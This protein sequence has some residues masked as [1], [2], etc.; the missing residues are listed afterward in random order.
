MK[1][2]VLRFSAVVRREMVRCCMIILGVASFSLIDAFYT[3][4][5]ANIIDRVTRQTVILRGFGLGCWLL[6]EGYMFGGGGNID[7]PRYLEQ[8]VTNLIGATDAHQFWMLWY[9]NYLVEQDI[10]DMRRW[11]CN[12]IRP[13]L[14]NNVIQ[15]RDGQ[16]ANPPYIYNDWGWEILDSLVT[17]CDRWHVGIIWDMHAAPGGQNNQ[18]ISDADGTARL[19]ADTTTYWPRTRDIW[20]QIAARY[21]NRRSII[22]YDLLNEPL[23]SNIGYNSALL[24]KLYVQL[25]TVIRTVDTAGIIFVEGQ[26]WARDFAILAPLTWDKHLAVAFHEYP[27]VTSFANMT[28]NANGTPYDWGALRT[29]YTIPLWHGETGEQGPPYTRNAQSTDFCNANNIGWSWWTHKKFNNTT[30]PWNCPKTT[31]FQTLIN[32][33]NNGGTKPTAANAKTWLFDQALRTNRTYCTFLPDMVRSLHPLNPDAPDTLTPWF[34]PVAIAAGTNRQACAIAAGVNIRGRHIEIRLPKEQRY[35]VHL[36]T[37]EGK[38]IETYHSASGVLN[39]ETAAL[40]VGTY[41]VQIQ[42]PGRSF[43]RAIVVCK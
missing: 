42:S 18:N 5:G 32:Y 7:R 4:S 17:W 12:A 27:P 37:V 3:T 41:I 40:P 24:R 34:P 29:T 36:Y 14:C 16:P 30:Q 2:M 33:W 21:K 1:K 28:G 22:G 39:V 11:G 10:K 9:K 8:A 15:P 6:P 20:Y 13:A 23:L 35:D 19:W 38:S 25:T 31:G 43:E 26:W